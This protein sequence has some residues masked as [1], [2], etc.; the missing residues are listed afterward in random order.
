MLSLLSRN[1]DAS[2]SLCEWKLFGQD[3]RTEQQDAEK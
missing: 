3:Y 2:V 1:S